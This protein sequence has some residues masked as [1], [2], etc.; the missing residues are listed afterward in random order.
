[1]LRALFC[2]VD[3]RLELQH[4]VENKLKI[5][6]REFHFAN[7][8]IVSRRLVKKI[9][10]GGRVELFCFVL[11]LCLCLCECIRDRTFSLEC[12]ESRI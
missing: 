4:G 3:T 7:L 6:F 10:E 9:F 12:G 1:M 5:V 11:D 8:R 2:R